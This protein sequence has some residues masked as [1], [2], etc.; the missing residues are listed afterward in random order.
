MTSSK[1]KTSALFYLL[2]LCTASAWPFSI[3]ANE[4]NKIDSHAVE[5][6]KR[7]YL[8]G[9]LPSGEPLKATTQGDVQLSGAQIA[10]VSCHQRSG[11]GSSEGRILIPPVTKPILFAPLKIQR[12]ELYSANISGQGTRPA[13]ADETLARVI[14][15]GVDSGG[16]TLDRLMPRFA[17]S[18]ADLHLLIAYLKS[19]TDQDAPGVTQDTIHF[20]TVVTDGVD[21]QKKQAM[22]GILQVFFRDKN[23]GTRFET[24]R[25]RK[26]PW[27]KE[28]QYQAY[29]K[30]VLHEWSLKGPENTWLSQLEKYYHQ[31]PVFALVSGLSN[32][33][34]QPMHKFCE[35][36]QT[37]CLFPNTDLPVVG[38]KN[39]YSFYFSKGLTLEAEALAEYLHQTKENIND[40]FIIQ[41]YRKNEFGATPATILKTQLHKLGMT[42]QITDLPIDTTAPLTTAYWQDLL[43]K[44]Q[45]SIMVLWLN[46]SDL[47][48]LNKLTDLADQNKLTKI[49]LSSSLAYPVEQFP[50]NLKDEVYLIHP[51]ALPTDIPKLLLRT[52]GWLKI[53]QFKTNDDV[54]RVQANTYFTTMVLGE[55]LMH[56]RSHFSREYFME[57]IEHMLESS[58][59]TSVY[60][61]FSLGLGQR[62]ASKGCYIL[63]L[64]GQ[65][66]STAPVSDWIVP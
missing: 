34:W 37:P 64:T 25:A 16:R 66:G 15:D 52:S 18:D 27:Q 1:V 33:G 42:N 46:K 3:Y 2:L 29:R 14:R 45:P 44:N 38:D 32:S 65:S 13:Y 31:Q 4:Q 57:K 51:F 62:F 59:T 50:E 30:W 60:P 8:E 40:I 36:Y 58:L 49:F 10:C 6:G 54:V 39:E 41:V 23:A 22:L 35:Q 7:I 24:K 55:A 19:L 28:W 12:R 61:R 63:K 5:L 53:K 56:I 20:A 17:L 43:Q 21:P 9:L 47:Q 48:E 11:L 26:T